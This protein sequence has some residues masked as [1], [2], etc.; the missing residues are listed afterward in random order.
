[1]SRSAGLAALVAAGVRADGS[2]VVMWM[3][4]LTTAVWFALVGCA[5]HVAEPAGV[6]DV[7]DAFAAEG[8][9]LVRSPPDD[10]LFQS[11]TVL[12]ENRVDV[13]VHVYSS[14]EAARTF[15]ASFKTFVQPPPLRVRSGRVAQRRLPDPPRIRRRANVLVVTPAGTS[16]A[17]GRRI[18]RAVARLPSR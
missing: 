3:I 16:P 5:G 11:V 12:V 18:E 13:E 1:M 9:E 4:G 6:A 8:V 14:P 17:L 7:R 10:V 15:H 2:L